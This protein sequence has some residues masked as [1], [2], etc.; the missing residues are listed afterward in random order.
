MGFRSRSEALSPAS[1]AKIVECA[2]GGSHIDNPVHIIGAACI[3]LSLQNR[4]ETGIDLNFASIFLD[5]GLL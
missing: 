2:T 1:T 5:I 4:A 3:G